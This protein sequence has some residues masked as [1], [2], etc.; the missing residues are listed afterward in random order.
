MQG[1]ESIRDRLDAVRGRC[2]NDGLVIWKQVLQQPATKP[3][4]LCLGQDEQH[5][6]VPQPL[7][8]DRRSERHDPLG[9]IDPLAGRR[10]ARF[11]RHDEPLRIG[12][13]EVAEQADDTTELRRDLVLAH[14][15]DVV[16]DRAAPDRGAGRQLIDSGR[17]ERQAIDGAT[18][19]AAGTTGES[20]SPG[21]AHASTASAPITRSSSACMNASRSPSRTALVLPVSWFDRRSLTIW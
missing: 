6:Q 13:L 18:G 20:H 3:R 11:G 19:A 17:T 21:R 7:A 1:I 12:R 16:I 8:D 10:V 14:R 5:G 9:R 2:P 4:L 15:H